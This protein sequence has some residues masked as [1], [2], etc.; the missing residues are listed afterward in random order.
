[1]K[2]AEQDGSF[3]AG[4]QKNDEDNQQKAEE[5]VIL[6]GPRREAPWNDHNEQRSYQILFKMK[7]N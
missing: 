5:I 7:N 4:D 6:M 1:M 3:R 2:V